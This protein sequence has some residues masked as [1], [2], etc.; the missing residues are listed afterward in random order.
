MS[1]ELCWRCDAYIDTDF[2]VKHFI[3]NKENTR[4]IGCVKH[5]KV[6]EED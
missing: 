1:M 5:K 2:D 6:M 3:H 4:I